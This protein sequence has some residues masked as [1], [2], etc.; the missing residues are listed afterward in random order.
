[1]MSRPG[2]PRD[3]DLAD[4]AGRDLVALV[5]EQAAA[6]VPATAARSTASGAAR[7]PASTVSRVI[8]SDQPVAVDERRP[9]KR[10]S[11]ASFSASVTLIA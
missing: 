9:P 6:A 4:L 7:R 3:D 10:S 5:V 8:V 1:M 11:N 2:M